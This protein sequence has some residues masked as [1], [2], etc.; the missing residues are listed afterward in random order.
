MLSVYCQKEK[1]MSVETQRGTEGFTVNVESAEDVY[2]ALFGMSEQV[3]E[4][5]NPNSKLG[6][7]LADKKD[8]L[9]QKFDL[10]EDKLST[11]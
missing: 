8:E 7:W 5:I 9:R 10:D 6:M 4:N 3:Y 2:N 11:P 1:E